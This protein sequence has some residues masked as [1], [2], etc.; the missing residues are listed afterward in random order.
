MDETDEYVHEYVYVNYVDF[1]NGS[2]A[3][4]TPF[5]RPSRSTDDNFDRRNDL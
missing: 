4:A 2:I 3:G 5:Q 1:L